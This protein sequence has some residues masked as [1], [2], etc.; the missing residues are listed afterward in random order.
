MDFPHFVDKT[1]VTRM[2]TGADY[3]LNIKR[4]STVTVDQWQW[5]LVPNHYCGCQTFSKDVCTLSEYRNN[6]EKGQKCACKAVHQDYYST[7]TVHAEVARQV[8][9]VLSSF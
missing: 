9:A 2:A 3:F 7:S 6:Y 1:M 8:G 5:E 4:P